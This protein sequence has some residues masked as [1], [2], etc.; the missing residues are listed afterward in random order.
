MLSAIAVSV[1]CLL[2][3]P[4]LMANQNWD[5]HNRNGISTASDFAKNYLN[6]CAPNSILFTNGDNDTFPLWYVQEVLRYRTD[7]RVV[8]LS[9]LNTDW[10]IDQMRRKAW[11]A[12]GIPQRLPE[13]KLRQGTNDYVPI[14]ERPGVTGF[15]DVDEIIGFV[16]DD[17]PKSKVGVGQGQKQ[18]DYI[19]SKNLKITVDK[20]KVLANPG[21]PYLPP[22]YHWYR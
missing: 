12:D 18:V 19:P 6:S 20:A 10:Y 9:L 11:D 15:R 1:V 14:Y 17:T 5:D 8:N 22:E 3:V 21:H 4:T 13:S 16:A 7:V 2:A